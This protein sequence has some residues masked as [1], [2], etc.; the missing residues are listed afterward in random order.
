MSPLV[1]LLL[2]TAVVALV[3]ESAGAQ[4]RYDREYEGPRYAPENWRDRVG[5]LR[6]AV[7][8]GDVELERH[9]TTG[10]V[11]ALLR[12]LEIPESSQSLV[13]TKT[14]L[15]KALIEP[16]TPRAIFF[17]D[18]AYVAWVPGAGSIEVSAVDP[19]LGA[20]FYTLSQSPDP[21]GRPRFEAET[22]LCLRCHDSYSLSGGGVPR[23]LMGS[24]IPDASGNQV[25]HEGWY[26]TTPSSPLERRWGGW[27]VTGTHGDARH[28][29]NLFV[30]DP[31]AAS[32]I[33]LGAGAN[34]TRLDDRIDTSRYPTSHS[35]I[36]A[37]LVLEHQVH[38]QNRITRTSYD[39]RTLLAREPESARRAEALDAIVAPLVSAMLHEGEAE[40]TGRVEGTAG[41]RED[42]ESRGPRDDEGRSLRELDLERFVFRYPMSYMVHSESFRG[43]PERARDS[44]FRQLARRLSDPDDP[45]LV[46]RPPADR[47]AVRQLLRQTVPESGPFLP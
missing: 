8:A 35:D 33:D 17:T 22:F 18:D 4:L 34:I 21:S 24:M 1:R 37:L 16:A 39:A 5:A 9:E 29:G 36:V 40:L 11:P 10:Y 25:F 32:E 31:G 42:F 38:V 14:S 7:E 30:R 6:D 3:A 2:F 19:V 12:A 41:F 43:L 20:V 47:E 15:Q 45:A 44:F 28:M 23:H 46:R 13:F 26:V 27:Y